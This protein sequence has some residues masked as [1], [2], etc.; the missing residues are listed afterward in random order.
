MKKLILLFLILFAF[1]CKRKNQKTSSV[2][3]YTTDTLD[4]KDKGNESYL[5]SLQLDETSTLKDSANYLNHY[6]VQFE[7][8]NDSI[9]E[10]SF[11]KAFPDN[12][13]AFQHLYGFDDRKGEMPLYMLGQNHISNYSKIRTYVKDRE[14]YKKMINITAKAKWEADNTN[15]LQDIIIKGFKSKTNLILD[16]LKNKDNKQVKEFWYFFFDGP[17]PKDPKNVQLYNHVLKV[18]KTKDKNMLHLVKKAHEDVL[19]IHE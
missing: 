13:K 7:A 2:S 12:F 16:L 6:Y 19:K 10:R 18:L 14:Y 9:S 17:H 15:A 1:G 5:Y 8:F 3:K 4:P 11:F